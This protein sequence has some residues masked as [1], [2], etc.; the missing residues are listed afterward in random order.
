MTSAAGP[1][2]STNQFMACGRISTARPAATSNRTSPTFL[3]EQS[4]LRVT[5]PNVTE[6]EQPFY[7]RSQR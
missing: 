1:R 4:F 2:T 7:E 6:T 3:A 5:A